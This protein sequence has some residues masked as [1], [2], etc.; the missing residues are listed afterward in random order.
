MGDV[1][2]LGPHD[3]LELLAT[4]GEALEVEATYRPNGSPP[5]AHLHPAQDESFEVLEGRMRARVDGE[6][7]EL[8]AGAELEIRRGS[9]H[10]MWNPGEAQARVRWRTAPAG[11]T[12]EWFRALDSLFRPD[13]AIARGEEVDFAALLRE[14]DDVFRLA[15]SG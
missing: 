11:R 9:V 8:K 7:V 14:Y 2:S 5:P 3:S 6:E 15:D 1:L 13:G 10:Q 12:E 4:D